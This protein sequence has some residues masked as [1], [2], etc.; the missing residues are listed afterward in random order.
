[1]IKT[2]RIN[3]LRWLSFLVILAMLA[4]LLPI[5]AFAGDGPDLAVTGISYP[6]ETDIWSTVP[7]TVTVKNVGNETA[8]G[9]CVIRVTFD[10][11]GRS[12]S[13]WYTL[14][15]ASIAPDEELSFAVDVW[16]DAGGMATLSAEIDSENNIAEADE[17]N[18]V[19]NLE[20]QIIGKDLIVTDITPSEGI[21]VGDGVLF[22]VTVKNQGSRTYGGDANYI[23]IAVDGNVCE[24]VEGEGTNYDSPIAPG[25]SITYTANANS[26]TW[27]PDH[28]G[29]YTVTATCNALGWVW[30]E[31]IKDNNS[32]SK[33]ITVSESTDPLP[34]MVP[35]A[36]TCVPE[37]PVQG[38]ETTLYVTVENQGEAATPEGVIMAPLAYVNGRMVGYNDTY[39]TSIPAGG[40]VTLPITSGKWFPEPGTYTL[41]A[42][43]DDM[44]RIRESDKTNNRYTN[45]TPLTI[46]AAEGPDLT[47]TGISWSPLTVT[48]GEQLTFKATVKNTGNAAT[49]GNVNCSFNIDGALNID[50]D[51]YTQPIQ[52]GQSVVLT[53]GATW[54]A[55]IGNSTVKAA[56]ASQG[57]ISDRNNDLTIGF[58]VD[59]A[60]TETAKS[61][62]SFV[63]TI[64]VNTHLT[65]LDSV[66][67]NYEGII[68]PRLLE[69]GIRTIR[70]TGDAAVDPVYT[71]KVKDLAA[72]GIHLNA[73]FSPGTDVNALIKTLFPAVVSAEGPNEYDGNGG[74]LWAD[75][76]R[77][78]SQTMYEAIRNDPEISHIPIVSTTLV[79]GAQSY[80]TLGDISQYIDYGNIHPY[81]GGKYPSYGLGMNMA[82]TI[83]AFG[84]KPLYATE[85]GYHTFN[86]NSVGQPGVSEAAAGKY[87]PRQ[88]FEL[89]NAGIV[90]TFQY[91]L[92]DNFPDDPPTNSEEHYGMIRADGTPKAAFYAVR[93]TTALLREPGASF[94]PGS[95]SFALSGH[96]ENIHHTLLQKSNGKFYLVLWAEVSAFDVDRNK[97]ILS[98]DQQVTLKFEQSVSSVKMYKPSTSAAVFGT[99]FNR[100]ELNIG[101]SDEITVLEITPAGDMAP[102]VPAAPDSLTAVAGEANVVLKW[103][104]SQGASSYVIKR[105]TSG[106]GVYEEIAEIPAENGSA[107]FNKYKDATVAN[108]ITYYYVVSAKNGGSEGTNSN[109]AICTPAIELL[110]AKW[111]QTD[112]GD[113][114]APGNAAYN[115]SGAVFTLR[116]V[117]HD[118]GGN[119]DGLH[120]LYREVSGD[121]EITARLADLDDTAIDA[122]AGVVIRETLEEGSKSVSNVMTP[123]NGAVFVFRKDAGGNSI[124]SRTHAAG[125]VKL[126]RKDDIFT[127]YTSEDGLVWTKTL[128]ATV[129][130]AENVYIGLAVSSNTYGEL[131]TAIFDNVVINSTPSELSNDA[132]MTSTIG[133]VGT[134]AIS[135]IPYD[136]TLS[137]MKAA[138]TPAP[139]AVFEIYLADGVTAAS[140]LKTGYKVIVTAEDQVTKAVYT[141]TMNARPPVDDTPSNPAAPATGAEEK[142]APVKARA[143]SAALLKA[144]EQAKANESGVK[145]VQLEIKAVEGASS[146]IQELPGSLF[147]TA[148]SKAEKQIEIKT[149]VGNIV[150]SDTMFKDSDIGKA[151]V[152]GI[153]LA[154]ADVSKLDE[155][156]RTLVGNRPVIEINAIADGKAIS[157]ENKEAPV[158]VSIDYTPSEEELKNPD[159]IVVYYIDGDGRL[160][161]VPTGKFDPAT[162]KVTFTT[163]HFSK[164]AVSYNFKTFADAGNYQWA[165][166]PMEF[167]ASKGILSGKTED[168]FNPEGTISRAEFIDALIKALGLTADFDTNFDD[169]GIAHKY[170]E[171]V[172]IAR[173]LGI[174]LGTG[175][176][177]FSPDAR[178]LRQ[179]MAIFVERA[180]HLSG[181]TL[182]AGESSELMRYTDSS[183]ISGYARDA[184]AAIIKA[185]I[186]IGDGKKRIDPLGKATRAQAATVLYR[187]YNK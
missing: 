26:G 71:G 94:V 172:G 35:V 125:W 106:G 181:K 8:S 74:V 163:T 129:N 77:S 184:V 130:M 79:K 118:L 151:E 31:S 153:S 84:S 5:T 173:K 136:T 3:K 15:N 168:T 93:N 178:I 95:F 19:F 81:T 103:L 144:F 25:Q 59:T 2:I 138:I 145:T 14:D 27:V 162:G 126:V 39:T 62:D 143:D 105:S 167:V 41:S 160:N 96:T 186:L 4:S 43:V 115:S 75:T 47:V 182:A 78:F 73:I 56:V 135:G 66:Y 55:V 176:N 114:E 97:N 177:K 58:S 80:I 140:D 137:R 185:E 52:P 67:S 87:I 20:N 155:K 179:E 30:D 1:M 85:T 40:S 45:P 18:N 101:I 16:D 86:G 83:P 128:S 154:A 124:D 133:T 82:N 10:Y 161:A 146:Y 108:A 112:I 44:N 17:N 72:S 69:A 9:R 42:F 99:Y 157:W 110:P 88:Y 116:G 127:A 32:F 120:Y 187:V 123:H 21:T 11:H 131:N 170:Y 159:Y 164:Y 150:V 49:S 33:T 109:E 60:Y 156:T 92:I 102:E 22:N 183:T 68:K 12:N 149:P 57:E 180:M 70:D 24:Y 98:P 175:N 171:S 61:A 28:S 63:D 174:T 158:T 76:L 117:G 23:T 38:E 13:G 165:Q 34:D 90:K 36:V 134:G 46:Q 119:K 51:V 139:G 65:W 111:L 29:S 48:A 169:V 104:P 166:K 100:D 113:V 91:Q 152:I 54:A 6:P 50:A 64:G 141:I 142:E 132:S 89:F 107:V 7:V 37:N 121:A 148:R 147:N 53:A 122:K